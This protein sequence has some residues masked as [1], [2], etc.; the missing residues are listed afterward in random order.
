MAETDQKKLRELI[1]SETM[2]AVC[3]DT[4]IYEQQQ[5]AFHRGL[6]GEVPGL[7]GSGVRLVMPDVVAREIVD[8]LSDKLPDALGAIRKAAR[9][10]SNLGLISEELEQQIQLGEINYQRLASERLSDFLRQADALEIRVAAFADLSVVLDKYFNLVAPFE[11]KKKSE[12]PDAFVLCALEAWAESEDGYVV[13]I[14]AD[15]GWSKFAETSERL[16]TG[17]A[18]RELLAATQDPDVMMLRAAAVLIRGDAYDAIR[19]RLEDTFAGMDIRADAQ[20]Y[21]YAEAEVTE[22]IVKSIDV[23]ELKADDLA[24]IR[25]ENGQLVI[26]WEA[27]VDLNVEASVSL[28]I[29]DSVD[30]D[31][32]TLATERVLREESNWFE[33][34]ITFVAIIANGELYLEF[35]NI[36]VTANHI[37]VDLGEVHPD[38]SDDSGV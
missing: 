31:Y 10:A 18:L 16:L 37:D 11:A 33:T 9:S 38:Y 3:I 25:N 17:V 20:S 22:L 30:K 24:I 8:H 21:H 36:E 15:Q 7:A 35:D 2:V 19:Q 4:N 27:R 14:S 6:L 26:S 28:S 29:Y 32:V 13:I 34:L 23:D 1:L 5:F 12:F